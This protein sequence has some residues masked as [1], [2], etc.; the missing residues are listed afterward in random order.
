MP[1]N[2][3][4]PTPPT[5]PAHAFDHKKVR[6]ETLAAA[7]L[8]L[9]DQ[10]VEDELIIDNFAG[11]GGASL[12]IELAV[13]RSP[14]YAINHDVEAVAL[15][16]ANHP[17]TVHFKT[18]VWEIDPT[19][20]C[21]GRPVGLAWFSP[22]CQHFSKAK[23][24]KPLNKRI[25]GLAWVVTRW[26]RAVKPRVIILENVEEFQTWGPLG[27][28]GRPCKARKGFTFRRW[29]RQLEGCGYR[30]E[31]RE[32]KA[33]DYGVPTS[34][35]RL[36]IIARS[37]G[38]PIVWP[39]PTHGPGR[40]PYRTAAECIDWSLECPS[41]FGRKRPLA[42]KTLRRIARGIERYVLD[43]KQPFLI[44]TTHAGD[45]RVHAVSEPVRT[46]TGA[47]RGEHALVAAALAKYYG[48][49][50]GQALESPLG[51]VTTKDRF[52]LLAPTMV[53]TD[54]HLSNATCAFD[55]REPINTITTAGG[56]AL[57]A[58][59]LIQTGYGERPGQEPR[60]PGL[61]KPL[62]TVV[63]CGQKHAVVAASLSKL[64]GT[65]TGQE[66]TAPLATITAG[67]LHHGVTAAFL[68]KHYGGHEASRRGRTTPGRA[69]AGW[70]STWPSTSRRSASGSARAR[71]SPRP[72]RRRATASTAGGTTATGWASGACSSCSTSWACRP[73]PR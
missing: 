27:K 11:G 10:G 38:K 22:N 2:K 23:G 36:F 71:P 66:A 54:M 28:D 48:T 40:L 65:S 3:K 26:A 19:V 49:G 32:L 20:L 70:P 51:T 35:K 58:A 39:E 63:A 57:A 7:T 41:V 16:Q 34:R 59:T 46:I 5:T 1:T 17:D 61:D 24:G 56:F 62:G 68:A 13:G 52:A 69:G 67:G 45:V 14:D 6:L 50:V 8:A 55:A 25:R 29:W 31:S 9:A 53:R 37:D 12:G 15:H 4:T 43:A 33:C 44:P 42:E 64:Y 73:R 21:A 72:I 18:D 47:H 30:V 60:V